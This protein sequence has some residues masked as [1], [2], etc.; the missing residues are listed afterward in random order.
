[1]VVDAMYATKPGRKELVLRTHFPGDDIAYQKLVRALLFDTGMD[2][3]R[4]DI[5]FHP[6]ETWDSALVGDPVPTATD[7]KKDQFVSL[8]TGWC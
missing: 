7:Y 2:Q 1:M 6:R 4:R 8:D 3:R 5:L